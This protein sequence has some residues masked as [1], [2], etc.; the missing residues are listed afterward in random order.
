MAASD[1]LVRFQPADY[2]PEFPYSTRQVAEALGLAADF[3]TAWHKV[4]E[5]D[6]GTEFDCAK[7]G[8][9]WVIKGR[10]V[11]ASMRR[12]KSADG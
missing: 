6:G 10:D 11:I 5:A 4:L 9:G 8:A 12:V 7:V 2:H 1:L 3:R